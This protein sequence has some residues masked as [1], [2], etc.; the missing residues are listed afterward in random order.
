MA[1]ISYKATSPNSFVINSLAGSGIGAYGATFGDSV[2]VGEY[3]TTSYITNGAGV[4]QGPQINNIK[5]LNT[6]SGIVNSATSGIP[7]V[8]IPNYLATLNINFNHSSAVRTQNVKL[9]VYDRTSINNGPSGCIVKVY[10]CVKPDTLQFPTGSGAN[11]WSTPF[12]SS[13]V[14]DLTA[15]PGTSGLRPNG[16]STVSDNHDWYV[17][18]SMSPSS[19]G[20]KTQVGILTSCEYL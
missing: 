9:Y 5:Y 19:I 2:P 14:L 3:Q 4:V 20:S 8:S 7:L 11:V 15:S 18:I 16:A 13:S 12:G 10:E 1:T 17:C 6:A